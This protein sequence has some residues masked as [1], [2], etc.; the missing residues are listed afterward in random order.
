MRRVGIYIRVSTDEQ[1]RVIEGSIKNQREACERYIDAENLKAEP[2][3]WGQLIDVFTD[4]GFSAKD[5]KRPALT[6]LLNAVAT[7]Q[8]D[9]VICTEISR[10]SRSVKDWLTLDQLF[11]D[12]EARFLTIRQDFDTGTAMGRAMMG[13]TR[14]FAQLEREQIAE[15]TKLSY[16]ARACRGLS[17]GGPVPFGLDLTDRKGYLQVNPAKQII[18]KDMFDILIHKAGSLQK[19]VD[20][21]T[22]QGY[23]RDHGNCWDCQSLARWIR[24]RALIGEVEVNARNKKKDQEKLSETEQYK[25]VQAVWEPVIERDTWKKANEILVNNYRK[26]KVNKWKHHDYLLTGLLSCPN[27]QRLIGSSGWGRAGKKYIHYKHPKG[28]GKSCGCDI[29]TIAA[30]KVERKVLRQ[31]RKLIKSPDI[32]EKLVAKANESL[33]QTGS[34]LPKAISAAKRQLNQIQKRLNR[35]TDHVLDADSSEEKTLWM[36]KSKTLAAEKESTEVEIARL[37]QEHSKTSRQNLDSAGITDA[38]RQLEDGFDDLPITAK[39]GLLRA[40]MREIV[41]TKKSLVVNVQNPSPSATLRTKS[42]ID[43]GGQK[44][45]YCMKWGARHTSERNNFPPLEL[46]EIIPFPVVP[47]YLDRSFLHQEYI[48]NGRPVAEIARLIDVAP[49]TIHKY[50]RAHGIEPRSSHGNL[51]LKPGTGLPFGM[52]RQHDKQVAHLRERKGI[53]QARELRRKGLSFRKIAEV[54][55]AM[56]VPTKTRTAKWQGRTVQQILV[57]NPEGQY[58]VD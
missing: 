43:E 38:L 1:A 40:I 26:L 31:L 37:E 56:E 53:E 49:S 29:P 42:A 50:L 55:N 22:V 6:N 33:K 58:P 5:M 19:T 54:L 16:Y 11:S 3:K 13:F 30:D 9:T 14:Q 25:V 7:R 45:A 27:G 21:I 52:R 36:E 34:G 35:A 2:D 12:H 41:V 48:E 24:N 10:M 32:I 8:I 57:K 23:R 46:A 18:A 28:T 17:N 44:L 39:Q 51:K 20:I 4:D 15:R 47:Q